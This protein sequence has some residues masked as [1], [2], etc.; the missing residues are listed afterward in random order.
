MPYLHHGCW[1]SISFVPRELK[2][3]VRTSG[4]PFIQGALNL[5]PHRM[6]NVV[7]LREKIRQD[8]GRM[9]VTCFG[10]R[11]IFTWGAHPLPRQELYL[12]SLM[13]SRVLTGFQCSHKP[14]LLSQS[15]PPRRKL[16]DQE[17]S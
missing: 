5:S 17:D 1:R 9:V 10:L 4:G 6:A 14:V 15:S 11:H 16:R 12:E 2:S 8:L 7:F 13:F 3:L